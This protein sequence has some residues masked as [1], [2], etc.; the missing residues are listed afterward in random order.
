MAY[1]RR[2][3]EDDPKKNL[4]EI[5][6]AGKKQIDEMLPR[7]CNLRSAA[8]G[9]LFVPATSSKTIGPR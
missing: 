3:E 8:Y 4:I 7:R 1:E 5:S 6:D 9:E 2:R